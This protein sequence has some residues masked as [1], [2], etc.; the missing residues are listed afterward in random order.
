MERYQKERV[1]DWQYTIDR[2]DAMNWSEEVEGDPL[3]YLSKHELSYHSLEFKL[4]RFEK[5]AVKL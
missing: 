2:E 5:E 1:C 4:P 3:C